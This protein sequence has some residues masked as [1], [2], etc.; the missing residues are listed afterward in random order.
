MK[1]KNF[2]KLAAGICF[3]CLLLAGCGLRQDA[4]KTDAK[5]AKADYPKAPVNIFVGYAPGGSADLVTRT[6]ADKPTPVLGQNVIV[7]NKPGGGGSVAVAEA[8]AAKPD[9]YTLA[10]GSNGGLLVNP[11]VTNVGYT[12]KNFR[13]VALLTDI[14]IGIAVKSGKFD[15]LQDLIKYAKENPGKIRYS[16]PGMNSTPHLFMEEIAIKEAIKLNHVPNASSPQ[17][18]AELLG[19]HIEMIVVNMPTF[20]SVYESKQVKVLATS[21]S[22]RSAE[23]PDVP[24]LNESRGYEVPISVWFGLVGPADI[25]KDVLAVFDSA[26][27]K[28]MDDPALKEAWNRLQFSVNYLGP[29]DFAKKIEKDDA[30]YKNVLNEMGTLKK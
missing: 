29:D 9:G 3:L 6:L 1:T 27:K 7:Q 24:T 23:M 17:S 22:K 21:D 30:L 8:L 28:A 14:P 26:V 25:P 13:P 20:K 15:T 5:Q 4:Q 16:T 2:L 12:A 10:L 19:G 18:I 11:Y